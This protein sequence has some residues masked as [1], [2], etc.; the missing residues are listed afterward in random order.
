LYEFPDHQR[1]LHQLLFPAIIYG[2]VLVLWVLWVQKFS[3][4]KRE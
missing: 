2:L 4:V 3:K 1:F